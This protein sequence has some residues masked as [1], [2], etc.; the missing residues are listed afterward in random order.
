MDRSRPGEPAQWNWLP[1]GVP[2]NE[3]SGPVQP[4][5]SRRVM[6]TGTCIALIAVGAILRFAIK[7]GSSHG[8]NVHVVGVI[9]L[10]AGVLGLVLSLVVWGPLN[11]ARRRLNRPLSAGGSLPPVAADQRM[12]R[13]QPPVAGEQPVYQEEPPL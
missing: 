12:Y 4:V 10:L 1:D 6:R 3:M 5:G 13:A 11:P 8:V 9:V 2:M 7:A